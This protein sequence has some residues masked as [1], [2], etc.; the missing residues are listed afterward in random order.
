MKSMFKCLSFAAILAVVASPAARADA[1][2]SSLTQGPGFYNG[3]GGS[4]SAF[5]V[6]TAPNSDGSSLQL[7]LSAI[8]RGIGPITPT[9]NTYMYTPSAGPLATWDFAFSVN[10]GSD[11]LSAYAYLIT[12]TDTTTGATTTFDPTTKLPDNAQANPSSPGGVFCN[13]CAY[14][15][16]NDGLQN[17]ENLGFDF[18]Q[19]PLAFSASAPDNYSITLTV[20][21]AGLAGSAIDTINVVPAP[22]P[23]SLVL[24]GTG[25]MGGIGT[26]IR[27]RRIA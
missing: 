11:P 6:V 21:G 24:L 19:N 20:T 7:G 2:N 3:N 9:K 18:L 16:S 26:M 25:L 12:V 17:A 14:V 8:N 15:G 23:G 13:G 4:N 10:T 22:E 5:D 1:Y 27:R